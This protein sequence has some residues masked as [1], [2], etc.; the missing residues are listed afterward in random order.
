MGAMQQVVKLM[1]DKS[2]DECVEIFKIPKNM[3]ILEQ[4]IGKSMCLF[5]FALLK[6]SFEVELKKLAKTKQKQYRKTMKY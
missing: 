3:K 4:A 1:L 6:G 2:A 5:S